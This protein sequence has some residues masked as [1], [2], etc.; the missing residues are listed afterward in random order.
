MPVEQV[1]SHSHEQVGPDHF[2]LILS[3]YG[4]ELLKG[5]DSQLE[6]YFEQVA[7]SDRLTQRRDSFQKVIICLDRPNT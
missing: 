6:A 1:M 3:S 2:S 4:I 7:M 5:Q